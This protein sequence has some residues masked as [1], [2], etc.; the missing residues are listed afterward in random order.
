MTSVETVEARLAAVIDAVPG[1]SAQQITTEPLGGGITNHNFLVAAGGKRFVVRLA[2]KGTRI[3]GIDRRAERAAAEAAYGAGVGPEVVAFLPE[4]ECL[5]TRFI[6]A[7]PIPV[8]RMRE[9]DVLAAVVAALRAFHAATS[10]P[11][12]FSPFRVVET[13]RREAAARSVRIPD[14]YERLLTRSRAIEGSFDRNPLAPRPCHNDLLNANFLW[15]EGRVFIVDYEYAGMGDLFFDLG[16]FS[17]NHE[18]DDEGD[19]QLLR[20]YFGAAPEAH[21]A[22]LK[23]MRVMSDFREAMWGVL[24]QG[25]STL[26][27]DYVDY[28]TRHFERCTR[29]ASDPRFDQWLDAAAGRP[30]S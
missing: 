14:A 2:G 29:Q 27:F 18:F 7:E 10:I 9:P 16:N 21:T 5:I 26:D 19:E 20:A 13:Y 23:L 28:A 15:R 3:L 22:R 17:V 25:I 8:A 6:E 4:L 30:E 11:S 24:Q 1:W 12:T